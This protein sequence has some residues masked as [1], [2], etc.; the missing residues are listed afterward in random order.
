[1]SFGPK[2]NINSDIINKKFVKGSFSNL[3]ICSYN[4]F[5]FNKTNNKGRDISPFRKYNNIKNQKIISTN[6]KIDS[7]ISTLTSKS[8][9]KKIINLPYYLHLTVQN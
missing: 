7:E 9:L 5:L 3:N 4:S 6:K 1:M 8:P 2:Q